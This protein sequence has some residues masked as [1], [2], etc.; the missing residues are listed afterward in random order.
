MRRYSFLFALVF[1]LTLSTGAL[2]ESAP[3]SQPTGI[4]ITGAAGEPVS[5]SQSDF[6]DCLEIENEA[7][8][9]IMVIELPEEGELS[10][11]GRYLLE[12]EAVLTEALDSLQFV[13]D[14]ALEMTAG[15]TVL[16]V[17]TDG[18]TA[19]PLPVS[20]TLAHQE[21][22]P[23]VAKDVE[24]ITYKDIA[25]TGKFDAV[26][27]DQDALSYRITSKAKRG[28][29]EVL[30]DGTFVYTPYPGKTGKDSFTY[31]ASD[32]FGQSSH[33]A[34]VYIKIEKTSAKITY[35]DMDGHESHYAALRLIEE[36][37]FTGEEIC[38]IYYFRPDQ[39]VTRAE[40]V[41]MVL[42]VMG[43]E[44]EIVPVAATG[45]ADDVDIPVWFKPYAQVAV[46]KGIIN[47]NEKPDGRKTMNA[48]DPLTLSQ[49]V[50]M[51]NNAVGVVDVSF[52]EDE[53]LP[54]GAEQ[55]TADMD[56]ADAIETSGDSPDWNRTVT[57]AE[58]A[59]MLVRAIDVYAET[60]NGSGLLSWVFGW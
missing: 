51:I 11:A 14:S 44:S 2:A 15:F 3:V 20:V 25:I 17:M 9:G 56:A 37:I 50:S 1:L 34:K 23:P 60:Q 42:K 32:P 26:D 49:A 43:M 16:P 10:Y 53:R 39:T 8:R 19:D 31:V 28:N 30:P 36:G 18:S 12:N 59:D 54:V 4:H 57:R 33:E 41:T 45:F 27:P 46:K 29:A 47:G 38:G 22:H 7:L 6:L 52:I 35:A 5:F 13:P 58:A 55:E 21:N 24:I 40:M 48:S